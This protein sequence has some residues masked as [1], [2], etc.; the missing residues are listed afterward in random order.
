MWPAARPPVGLTNEA[1]DICR[2]ELAR[3]AL[4]RVG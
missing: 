3:P 1:A 2:T 4:R